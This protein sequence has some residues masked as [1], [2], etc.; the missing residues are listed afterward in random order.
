MQKQFRKENLH[1][2]QKSAAD[3]P[4]SGALVR[5]DIGPDPNFDYSEGATKTGPGEERR[6]LVC[7]SDL[8]PAGWKRV[9]E[10]AASGSQPTPGL[11]NDSRYISVHVLRDQR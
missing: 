6:T 8:D 7:L 11:N 10:E 4:V 5:G 3:G 9:H 2:F 1:R